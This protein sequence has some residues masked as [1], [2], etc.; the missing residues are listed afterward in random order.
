VKSHLGQDSR[1]HDRHSYSVVAAEYYDAE[2]HPTCADFRLASKVFL[3]RLFGKEKIVGRV[4]DIGCG[5]SL[6]REMISPTSRFELVLVDDSDEMLAHNGPNTFEVR[7]TDVEAMPF[8]DCEF[9]WVFAIL[10]DPYNISQAWKNINRALRYGG[11]CV[12][13]I[14]SFVWAREFRKKGSHERPGFARFVMAGGAELFLPSLI[15]SPSQQRTLIEN[16]G[17][18]A[19]AMDHVLVDDV[20]CVR[21][22]KI[23]E[24]L[25]GGDPIIDIYRAEKFQ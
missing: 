5:R 6:L 13:I 24:F 18:R 3:E 12:F 11:R 10:G 21:S 23:S 14:P 22:R 15:Y 17:L 1:I 16:A 2:L 9:E 7:K 25:S 8:G 20:P 4:A 19:N